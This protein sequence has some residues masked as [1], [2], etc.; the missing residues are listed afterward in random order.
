MSGVIDEDG[1]QWEHCNCCGKL[2]KLVE[3]R[4]ESPSEKYPYG[5]DICISCLNQPSKEK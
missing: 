1:T 5:R 3:L 2:I 4:Y